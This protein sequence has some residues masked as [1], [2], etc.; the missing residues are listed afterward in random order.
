MWF[1]SPSIQD[2]MIQNYGCGLIA[3]TDMLAYQVTPQNFIFNKN[4]YMEF[5]YNGNKALP[6][7]GIPTSIN[8]TIPVINKPIEIEPGI[9]APGPQIAATLNSCYTAGNMNYYAYWDCCLDDDTMLE[10]IEGMID[11]DIPVIMSIGPHLQDPLSDPGISFYNLNFPGDALY[12]IT[13]TEEP[14]QFVESDQKNVSGHYFTVT[15]IFIDN[16]STT[17]KIMLRISSWGEEYYIDYSEYRTYIS[18]HGDQLTSSIIK[19][20]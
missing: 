8:L 6:L 19:I 16:I 13:R 18:N 11:R 15:G 7:T 2:F 17:R 3:F 20:S 14:Y 12:D 10:E 9:G 5:V 4:D 1:T